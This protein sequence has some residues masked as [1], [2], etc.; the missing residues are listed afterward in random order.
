[1]ADSLKNFLLKKEKEEDVE[2]VLNSI[3]TAFKN[4]NRMEVMAYIGYTAALKHYNENSTFTKTLVEERMKN[5]NYSV[6]FYYGYL[7]A[8]YDK[9][10]INLEEYK[11][12]IPYTKR[13]MED[14]L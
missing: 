14:I 10:S 5:S 7:R 3:K 8:M 1:M 11:A 4:N 6:F 12:L 13:E 2:N 9:G